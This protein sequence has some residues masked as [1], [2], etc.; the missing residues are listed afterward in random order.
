MSCKFCDE[1]TLLYFLATIHITSKQALNDL[2]MDSPLIRIISGLYLAKVLPRSNPKGE[3]FTS[4]IVW[5]KQAAK[6][7]KQNTL[8]PSF[9]CF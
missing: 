2:A 6:D 1:R 8:Q 3:D 7:P 5:K 4:Q 9:V